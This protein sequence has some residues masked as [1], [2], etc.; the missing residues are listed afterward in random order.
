MLRLERALL[1]LVFSSMLVAVPIAVAARMIKLV[2]RCL[3]GHQSPAGATRARTVWSI[4]GWVLLVLLG[5]CSA[6]PC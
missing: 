2:R 1:A 4:A 6:E 5:F 3:L